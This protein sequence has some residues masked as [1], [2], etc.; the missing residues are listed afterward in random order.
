[1]L[2]TLRSIVSWAADYQSAAKARAPIGGAPSLDV[3][4]HGAF[5]AAVQAVLYITCYKHEAL[6]AHEAGAALQA[7]AVQLHEVLL[8]P[9]NPLKFSLDAIVTEFERLSV[10]DIAD[11]VINN[12]RL[13]VASRTVT[14]T[15]NVLDDFFPFDPLNGF[16]QSAALVAPFYQEWVSRGAQRNAEPRDSN[17]SALSCSDQADASLATSLQGMSMTPTEGAGS[18]SMAA[19]AAASMG[20]H[21]RRRLAENRANFSGLMESPSLQPARPPKNMP[22]PQ[23]WA[24]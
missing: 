14:G 22:P 5:Y 15:P 10:C 3:A 16:R 7:L 21:M 13:I 9:L 1:M 4:L 23:A 2:A 6:V 19:A 24:L 20:D 12:E 8:G 17:Q 18:G 11:V